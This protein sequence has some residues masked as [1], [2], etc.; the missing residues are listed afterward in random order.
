[1]VKKSG[2]TLNAAQRKSVCPADFSEG[3]VIR[4]GDA[5]ALLERLGSSLEL[6]LAKNPEYR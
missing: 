6:L 5:G 1:M 2:I 3:G 4:R